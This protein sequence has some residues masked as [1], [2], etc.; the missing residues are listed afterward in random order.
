MT[1]R[2]VW[3][4]EFNQFKKSTLPELKKITE[5]QLK[6]EARFFWPETQVITLQLVED[7]LLDIAHYQFKQKEDAYYLIPTKNYNIK[8]RR[9]ELI[10]KPQK[11]SSKYAIGFG[12][13]INLSQSIQTSTATDDESEIKEILN[14]ITPGEPLFVKK[15]SFT[16]KFETHPSIK[17]ELAR[18]E[19]NH[20]YYFTLCIEGRSQALVEA[21]SKNLLGKQPTTDY[22]NF[23][24]ECIHDE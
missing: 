1:R 22:V 2:L 15:D 24:K 9:G 21:M 10:Y 13:K 6:W 16:F 7:S 17:L 23:L 8:K 5:D 3:N 18:I 11:K 4:F 20:I 12:P 14:T 19:I